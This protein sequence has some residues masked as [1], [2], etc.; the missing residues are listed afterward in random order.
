ML[1]IY[2][3]SRVRG[4]S[5]HRYYRIYLTAAQAANNKIA[6]CEIEFHDTV[7]G[8]DIISG[9]TASALE[10]YTG[11]DAGK[12]IDGSY[13]TSYQNSIGTGIL[14]GWWK[15]DFGSGND[16]IVVEYTIAIQYTGIPPKSWQFQW[17]DNNSDWTTV[18]TVSN[19][20]GWTSGSAG[21]RTF[22]I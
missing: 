2:A 19:Q 11:Y 15:Y 6:M 22:T 10:F 17:S 9:G 16:V 18:D 20:T 1:G 8:S 4:P 5:A 3:N 21:K 7:G 12:A 14:P 13:T